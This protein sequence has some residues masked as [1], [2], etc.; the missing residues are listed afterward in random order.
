MDEK[1]VINI[2]IAER[3]YPMTIERGNEEKIR[4]A[5]KIL[6]EQILQYR[7]TYAGQDNQ[8]YMAMS[9]LDFVLKMLKLTEQ[10][11]IDP[12]IRQIDQINNELANYIEKN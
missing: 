10:Q 7:Q 1:L 2:I 11:D 5:A 8:D 9:A 4:R 12:A 6:N 3:R